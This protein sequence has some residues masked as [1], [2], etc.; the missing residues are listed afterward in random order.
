MQ[1]SDTL[2]KESSPKAAIQVSV[3]Y[4]TDPLCCWSWAF[5]EQWQKF[6]QQF[7]GNLTVNYV[8]GGLL[9]DW[10]NFSDPMNNVSKPVQMGPVWMEAKHITGVS[11]NDAIWMHDAPAS[12][13]PACIAVKTAALQSGQAEVLY[14]RNL[15]ESV[16][17]QGKNI[18]RK[19]VL[20]S[21]AEETAKQFPGTF[22]YEH[23]AENY[24]GETALNA[25][26]HDLQK[27]R[28]HQI[29]RFPTLTM[30]S[31]RHAGVQITGYRPYDVL[32][33]ALYVVAPELK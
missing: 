23:F 31:P 18:S 14:L 3:T 7:T 21:I 28:Y 29:S 17:L 1:H 19:E 10:K 9:S 13:Y 24:N 5:E 26:R 20:L 25:F 30:S 6:Q 4:Y 12:S 32:L 27:V 15:R 16:M 8:M 22:R 2:E 33:E 11:I